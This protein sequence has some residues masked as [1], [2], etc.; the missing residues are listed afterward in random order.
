MFLCKQKTAYE[1]R[2]SD[3]SSDVCSSDLILT[4][5]S[6]GLMPARA[7]GVSSIGETILSPPSTCSTSMPRPLYWPEV[8]SLNCCRPSLSR[9]SLCGSDRMGVVSGKGV[10]L[11]VATGGR[12]NLKKK[13]NQHKHY[14]INM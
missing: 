8:S 3:W 1:V 14:K 12:R 11:R 6:P 9:Y 2:I 13:N 10:S 4:M 7:A 5:L